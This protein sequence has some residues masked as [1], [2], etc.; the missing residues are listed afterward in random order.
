VPRPQ[1]SGRALE[2]GNGRKNCK[3]SPD[4]VP[5]VTLVGE[6]PLRNTASAQ[7]FCDVQDR[8]GFLADKPDV[9]EKFM[10]AQLI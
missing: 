5:N 3:A 2:N 1:T 4:Q 10:T 8:H 9:Y 6:C 7:F